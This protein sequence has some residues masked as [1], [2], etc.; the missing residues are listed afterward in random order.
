MIRTTKWR[1]DTCGCEIEYSWDDSI[2]QDQRTHSI[3]KVNSVCVLHPQHAGDPVNHFVALL[4]ENSSK[5]IAMGIL[6]DNF[7]A[8]VKDVLDEDGNAVG[9]R[10]TKNAAPVASS[11]PPK[12]GSKI[13]TPV[14]SVPALD[15]PSKDQYQALLDQRLGVG[16]VIVS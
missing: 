2:P 6:A 8:I 4:D 13:R 3:S 7:P 14:I 15:Q 5:N 1:P 12:Q 10:F 9:K 11:N 16:K